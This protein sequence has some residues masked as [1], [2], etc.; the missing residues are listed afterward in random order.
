[1]VSG[2]AIVTMQTTRRIRVD[3]NGAEMTAMI[4]SVITAQDMGD[5][6]RQPGKS[7]PISSEELIG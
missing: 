5:P 3:H 4:R 2:T 1:M 6:I 7:Q